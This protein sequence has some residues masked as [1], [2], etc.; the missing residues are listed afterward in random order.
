MYGDGRLVLMDNKL[1]PVDPNYRRVPSPRH[2]PFTSQQSISQSIELA[3]P[4]DRVT[5]AQQ[6]RK[7]ENGGMSLRSSS[8]LPP[9]LRGTSPL[10]SIIAA[11]VDAEPFETTP[12]G[13]AKQKQRRLKLHSQGTPTSVGSLSS[14]DQKVPPSSISITNPFLADLEPSVSTSGADIS[15][16]EMTEQ[17]AQELAAKLFTT[18]L[19]RIKA[20]GGHRGVP[21]TKKPT[22]PPKPTQSIES[23]RSLRSESSTT[24]SPSAPATPP[25]K[26]PLP[27]RFSMDQSGSESSPH[28]PSSKEDRSSRAGP[29][30][31]KPPRPAPSV[32]HSAS[33]ASYMDQPSSSA[34]HGHHPVHSSSIFS[35]S[36]TE[37]VIERGAEE[38][39]REEAG[40]DDMPRPPK[41][42]KA[43]KPHPLQRQSQAPQRS[44]GLPD[45]KEHWETF[46]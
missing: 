45:T 23:K 19:P 10:H 24:S 32:W 37:S 33:V 27:A 26:P 9:Q 21:T 31:P 6:S 38:A 1:V 5:R 12:P 20:G 8:P 29:R 17:E 35:Q 44:S 11:S 22:P 39:I 25:K 16:A 30:R 15:T 43:V 13:S 42:A 3:I 34:A 41:A 28:T 2:Q 46:E 40:D 4:V 36:S 7:L 18:D 14:I